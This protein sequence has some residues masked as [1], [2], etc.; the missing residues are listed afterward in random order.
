MV[1]MTEVI[2]AQRKFTI[3]A[4]QE[5]VW[6]LLGKVI[7]DSLPGLERIQIK[8]QD[9]FSALFTVKLGLITLSMD[10]NAEIVD[11]SPPQS[12]AVVLRMKGVGGMFRLNQRVIFALSSVNHG[13]TAVTS[14][15]L[16]EKLGF[17]FR[18]MFM[19]KAKSFAHDI[20]RSIEERLEQLA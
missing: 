14:K 5:R 13:K 12:L 3:D 17:L 1:A 6:N 10:V 8:D 19:R 11:I 9:R 15:A 2:L 20:F 7:F 16:G 4:S 18:I